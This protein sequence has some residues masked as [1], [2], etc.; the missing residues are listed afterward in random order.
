MYG[1]LRWLGRAIARTYLVGLIEVRGLDAVPRTGGLLVC[2]N[3]GSNADPPLVPAFLPRADSWS[4][5]K[6]EYFEGTGFV[7]WIFRTYH[8][9]PVV[10]HTADRVALRRALGLLAAGEAVIVYPEGTRVEDARLHTPEPGAGF[11]ALRSRAVVQPVAMIG[12]E[13]CF[14]KGSWWPRRVPVQIVYGGPF[15]VAERWPDGRRVTFQEAAEAIML[16]IAE[17]L[18]AANR[19]VFADLEGARRRL[20]PIVATV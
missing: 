8:S 16:R 12:T 4:M 5:A 2:S 11:I 13:D 7:P 10:R 18:P 17:L 14:P 20:G 3:H 1:F 6:S 19:G 15:R 9:F